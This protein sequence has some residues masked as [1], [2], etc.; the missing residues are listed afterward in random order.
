MS[1]LGFFASILPESL[2]GAA[3]LILMLVAAYAGDAAARLV[4]WL[5]VAALVIAGL[6][7]TQP[8]VYAG[9]VIF[10]GLYRA[11]AFADFGKALIF[12]AAAACILVAP[13]FFDDDKNGGGLRAEY[14][15]LILLAC[16]GMSI[17]VSATD[18]ITLYVG[19]ELNSL[20]AYVLAS[21]M[22]P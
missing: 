7:L 14:P 19:L 18:F 3:A 15:V 12:A 4:S 2:L 9:G 11:D 1:G 22:R 10:D 5:S 20:A 21:F 17:M 13:R 16:V 8:A 6:L